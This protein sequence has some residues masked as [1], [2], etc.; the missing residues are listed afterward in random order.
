MKEY[1]VN[2]HAAPGA[3]PG[4]TIASVAKAA[5]GRKAGSFGSAASLGTAAAVSGGRCPAIRAFSIDGR[6]KGGTG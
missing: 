2:E 3:P 1:T 4:F 6:R 5:C